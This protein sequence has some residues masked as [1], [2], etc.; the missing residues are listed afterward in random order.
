MLGGSNANKWGD[1]QKKNQFI[2]NYVEDLILFKEEYQGLLK[3]H[4]PLGK[5]RKD[6]EGAGS[7]LKKIMGQPPKR[8]FSLERK[9]DV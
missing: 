8:E 1:H 6:R 9:N 7:S 4:V 3:L 2:D 5:R